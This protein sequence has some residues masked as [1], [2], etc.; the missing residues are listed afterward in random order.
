M[1]SE[2]EA[3]IERVMQLIKQSGLS[4]NAFEKQLH[5]SQGT[6]GNWRSGRNKLSMDAIIKVA[7]YFNVSADYLL[8]LTDERKPL[9]PNQTD[10]TNRPD[11]AISNDFAVKYEDIIKERVFNDLAKL[12]KAV[13]NSMRAQILVVIATY[14]HRSGIDT[15]SIV[16]Y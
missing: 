1:S 16:G 5:L 15:E 12:Y 13:D 4:D 10:I 9:S 3:M 2:G 7:R 14:L 6:V 8:G 11:Y